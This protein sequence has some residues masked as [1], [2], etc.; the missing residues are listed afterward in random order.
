MRKIVYL[1]LGIIGIVVILGVYHFISLKF[2][3]QD[4]L[5]KI[6]NIRREEICESISSKAYETVLI[7]NSKNYQTFYF[8]SECYQKMAIQNRDE[9]LCDKVEERKSI[10]FDGSAISQQA[11]LEAVKKKM[12]QDFTER[13]RP[14]TIHRIQ[15]VNISQ[16]PNADTANVKVSTNGSLWSTYEFS[17]LLYNQ[18]SEFV[19]VLHTLE[20]HMGS[21]GSNNLGTIIYKRDL[22]KLLGQDYRDGQEYLL[23]VKLKLIKDDAG[24]L[25]RSNLSEAELESKKKTTLGFNV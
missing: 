10:F 18:N 15:S 3:N 13:V 16:I 17:I 21:S 23:E 9:I 22:Q 5:E 19:G 7:G 14:E 2:V 11:C 6:N 20:T 1:I 4:A 24:Q 12:N 8:R 25:Q